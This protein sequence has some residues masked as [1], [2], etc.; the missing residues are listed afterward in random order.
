MTNM[1][2]GQKKVLWELNEST[3]LMSFVSANEKWIPN[4]ME[5]EI[6]KAESSFE[7]VKPFQV[8]LYR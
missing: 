3:L 5:Y 1:S 7:L 8:I 6:Q 2:D 4:I